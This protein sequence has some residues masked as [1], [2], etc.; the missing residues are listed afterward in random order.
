MR[1][2][3]IFV[4]LLFLLAGRVYLAA[5]DTT[6][7]YLWLENIESERALD[8]ARSHNEATLA[9]LK[10][11]P[12]F[13]SIYEKCLEI[14]DSKE[15]IAYPSFRGRYLYNFWQDAEH[16][17]GVWRRTSM[18]EY[19]KPVPLWEVVLDLDDL[20]RTENVKWVFK[21][22]SW[23][24]PDF[25]RCM[26]RLS[27][28]GGDAVVIREFDLESKKFVE[29]GFTMEEAKGSVSW[30]DENTLYVSSGAAG[31]ATTSSGYARTVRVWKRGA[32]LASAPVLFEGKEKDVSVW[33]GV[34]HTPERDYEFF[35]RGMTFYTSR[36]YVRENGKMIKLDIPEDGGFEGFFANQLLLSLKTDWTVN[37]ATYHQGSLISLDYD[38]LLEGRHEVSVIVT[39]DERS[40]VERVTRTRNF[41]LV[42]MLVNV[43]SVLYK[44]RFEKGEW[45]RSKVDAPDYGSIRIVATDEETDRFFFTYDSFLEPTTLYL[46]NDTS[47]AK[48]KSLPAFF[49]G[50]KYE[51]KQYE[52][53]SEDGT[54]IPFFVVQAKGTAYDGKNPTLLYGYGG[55]EIAMR[56]RY[57]AT[58]GTSW[59]ERGGVYVLANIRGGGEF[60]PRWH[61]AALKEHR[62]R[63]FDDFIAVA[64]ELIKKGITSPEHLGIMGGSNGG[65]LVGAVFTQRPEL[66]NAVVCR[67]P[68]LDMKRYNKLL[69]GASWMGEYGNPDVPEE[70][71]YIRKYSPYHNLRPGMKYPVVFFSTSTRD[72]RVHPGHARKMVAK[73]EDMG[74]KVYYYENIEGG[75]AAATTNKQRAFSSGLVFT[76]LLAQLK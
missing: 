24:Y 4:G 38:K 34:V 59:L 6:D 28:G 66:F 17:R 35:S 74:Y 19:R 69:A 43:R 61:L 11:H 52:A 23:L 21:G 20:S 18:E 29:N 5:Q 10:S 37:G 32:S 39:P 63:A 33:G 57:S 48:V 56:P 46:V 45:I 25:R 40:S 50:S 68:L 13:D 2:R 65:L 12:V 30:K 73:M 41:L 27:R 42:G 8:W 64:E 36:R 62:Q 53:T 72:D 16:E 54:R 51:V 67:V 31:G 3:V 44:Y 7:S 49:D 58:I 9:A 55:F 60:G 1:I 47:I 75:H 22:V 71:E 76:Y 26:V 15:R 70:W 14:Y